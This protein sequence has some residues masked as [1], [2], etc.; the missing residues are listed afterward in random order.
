MDSRS[1]IKVH[2]DEQT[3]VQSAQSSLVITHP[4]TNRAR[5]YLTSVTRVTEQALVAAADL[6]SD[7]NEKQAQFPPVSPVSSPALRNMIACMMTDIAFR[8]THQAIKQ[9]SKINTKQD[10]SIITIDYKL[11]LIYPNAILTGFR[12]TVLN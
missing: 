6:W 4:S 5:Q 3:Q 11:T 10:I 2:T 9:T 8:P 12:Q 1:Q 7:Q